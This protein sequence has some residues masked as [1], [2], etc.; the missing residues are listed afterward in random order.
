M[1]DN[2]TTELLQELRDLTADVNPSEIIDHVSVTRRGWVFDAQW[3]DA[4]HAEFER[5]VQAIAA[6]LGSG[7][8][9]IEAIAEL[10]K[11]VR[12]AFSGE[13]VS[14]L[15]EGHAIMRAIDEV[16]AATLGNKPDITELTQTYDAGFSNGVMAVY[17]QLEGIDDYE[18]LQ[19]FIA[20]YW[21][22]GEGNDER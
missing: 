4:W 8:P 2:R 14:M 16:E 5:I 9:F 3:L 13:S 19:C 10:R 20:E 17:Q 7:K 12:E 11:T 22:E 21:G 18:E 1:T 6:T 15:V